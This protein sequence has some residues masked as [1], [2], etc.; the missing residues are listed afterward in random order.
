MAK[1]CIICGEPAEFKIKDGSEF[2]CQDCAQMQFGDISLL[3]K[4][5]DDAKKLKKYIDEKEEDFKLNIDE[6][7]I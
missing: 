1:K 4:V 7:E 3:V 5:E 6:E 2:Y